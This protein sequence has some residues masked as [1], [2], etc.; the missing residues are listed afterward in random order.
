M[1]TYFG[2]FYIV[3]IWFIKN[4]RAISVDWLD[5]AP[6]WFYGNICASFMILLNYWVMIVFIIL[7]IIFNEA[8]GQ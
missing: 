2:F 5:L 4:W 6:I 1:V 7:F 8:I 3:C